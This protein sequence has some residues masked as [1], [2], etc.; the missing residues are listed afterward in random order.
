MRRIWLS[1]IAGTLAIAAVMAFALFYASRPTVLRVAVGPLKGDDVR[2]VGAIAGQLGRERA[3]IRLRVL[4]KEGPAEAAAALDK[5]EVDLAV[6]RRDI[7]MSATGQA[8]VLVRT[9]MVAIIAVTSSGAKRIGDLVGR[10]VGVVG[11]GDSN[12]H[13]F[14]AVLAHYE[15]SPQDVRMMPVDPDYVVPMLREGRIDVL[16]IAGPATGKEMSE[17]VAAAT[18]DGRPPTFIPISENDALAQRRSVY[19]STEIVAGAFGGNPPRP[20]ES[21]DTIGFSHYLVA[22][23]TLGEQVVGDLAKMLLSARN[24][25]VGEFPAARLIKAPETDKDAAVSV[26][27]GAAAYYD[28]EQKTFFDRYSDFF[29]LAVML[30]SIL[31]SAA[32]AIASRT[33][34]GARRERHTVLLRLTEL[35]MEARNAASID[36]LQA[37]EN[38]I[39]GILL[40]TLQRIEA[41]RPDESW[42]RGFSLGLEQAR[43]LIAER[44][45]ALAAQGPTVTLRSA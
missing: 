20:A 13:V 25:I 6:V 22:R 16:F 32:A 31:G 33:R 12:V 2:L 28:G 1:T 45:A 8:V 30:V 17:A 21:V 3:P 5:G 39:D 9:N 11:R 44:R 7:T 38:E 40:D 35:M 23:N 43:H 37:L 26:H 10:N 24:A 15:I 34:S 27:P 42:V 29:Y 36:R 41:E 18:Q 14:E 19:E 4:E